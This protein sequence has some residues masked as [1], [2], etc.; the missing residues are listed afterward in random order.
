MLA[1]L[2]FVAVIVTRTFADVGVARRNVSRRLVLTWNSA[3]KDLTIGDR[4]RIPDP[5]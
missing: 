3:V 4:R 1:N 2:P 5:V